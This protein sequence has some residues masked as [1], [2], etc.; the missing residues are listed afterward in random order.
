MSKLIFGAILDKFHFELR[1]FNASTAIWKMEIIQE[2]AGRLVLNTFHHRKVSQ[3]FS[4]YSPPPTYIHPVLLSP[5]FATEIPM[6][7]MML[8]MLPL[9]NMSSLRKSFLTKLITL[10][11]R[12]FQTARPSY[13]YFESYRRRRFGRSWLVFSCP[14]LAF[15]TSSE[16]LSHLV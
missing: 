13:E 7:L 10:K 15:L 12:I 1:H 6:D 9:R 16:S 4:C 11:Y 2:L 14:K 5:F 8:L 3:F